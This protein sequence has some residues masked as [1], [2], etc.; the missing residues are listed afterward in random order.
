MHDYTVFHKLRVA[1]SLHSAE[2]FALRYFEFSIHCRNVLI[3][4]RD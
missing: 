1:G 2:I 3:F 4:D